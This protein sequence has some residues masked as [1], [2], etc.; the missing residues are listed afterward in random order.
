[1]KETKKERHADQVIFWVCLVLA[2]AL[3]IGSFFCP[4]MGE[5]HPSVLKAGGI[6]VAMQALGIVGKNLAEGKDITFHKD[7]LDITIGDNDDDKDG[8]N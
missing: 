3:F 2:A 1:M 8:N 4:P 5:I 7:D 6:L